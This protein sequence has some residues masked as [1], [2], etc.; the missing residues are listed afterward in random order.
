MAS[1]VCDETPPLADVLAEFSAVI[2]RLDG[3]LSDV[4]VLSGVE[5]DLL[6]LVTSARNASALEN[7][8]PALA[9]TLAALLAQH[10]R[11][12][13]QLDVRLGAMRA[14][15]SYLKASVEA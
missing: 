15:G 1:N 12:S 9:E 8:E 7:A 13:A 3:N 2:A 4:A 14:F 5:D 10:E 11:A 6:R